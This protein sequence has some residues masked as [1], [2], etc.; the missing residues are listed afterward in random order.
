ML[1]TVERYFIIFMLYSFVGWVWESV[2][3]SLWCERKFI[4]RGFLTGPYCPIYGCGAVLGLVVL[5]N[6]QN[7]LVLFLTAGLLCCVLEY[8]TSY[9]MEKLFKARW[10]DYSNMIFNIHGRVCL[11][12]FLIFG[13]ATVLLVKVLNPPVMQRLEM[14]D[15]KTTHILSIVLFAAFITDSIITVSGLTGFNAKLKELTATLEAARASMTDRLQNHLPHVSAGNMYERL[16]NHFTWQQKRI[17]NAFPKLRSTRYEHV[18][19]DWRGLILKYKNK[20]K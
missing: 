8:I 3:C 20:D 4:N 11:L 16:L 9:V 15:D 10:W 13:G 5:G 6:I 18:L 17:I 12:G 2:F 7:S 1:V 19:S 14:L